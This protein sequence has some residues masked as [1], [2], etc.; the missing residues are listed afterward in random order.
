MPTPAY[1]GYA[2]NDATTGTSQTVSYTPQA[3]GN[4]LCAIGAAQGQAG[5]LTFSAPTDGTNTYAA[6]T[7]A[8]CSG[9]PGGVNTV[10][11][12]WWT[13]VHSTAALTVTFHWSGAPSLNGLYVFEV[14][15]ANTYDTGKGATA[16]PNAG[17]SPATTGNFTTLLQDLVICVCANT[18]GGGSVGAGF[19]GFLENVST[20]YDSEYGLFSAG[21]VAGVVN[22]GFTQ[23]YGII[24][25]G[26]GFSSGGS[27]LEPTDAVFFGMT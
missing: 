14:S 22:F 10:M 8:S 7:N 9:S 19:T 17:S 11:N 5:T 2:T 13:T 4:I 25:A 6:C 15:G 16:D 12:A 26:F 1:V 3:S 18:S 20:G 27:V 23:A 21:T 24:A